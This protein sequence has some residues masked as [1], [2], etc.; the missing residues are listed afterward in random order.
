MG[1]SVE[2]QLGLTPTSIVEL[3]DEHWQRWVAEAHVLGAVPSPAR[4]REWCV[5]ASGAQVDAVQCALA[6]IAA[7]DGGDDA[8]AAL[9]LSALMLPAATK[10]AVQ[11]SHLSRDIDAI[12]AGQLW[13]EVRTF[14]WQSGHRFAGNVAWRVRVGAMREAGV[15]F[16]RATPNERLN[17]TALRFGSEAELG[18]L[19]EP[20]DVRHGVPVEADPYEESLRVLAWGRAERLITSADELLLLLL[21]KIA[22]EVHPPSRRCQ[23]ARTG[24]MTELA[25]GH[26][27]AVLGVSP[28]TI[29]RHTLHALTRLSSASHE[30]RAKSA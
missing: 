26:A 28:R 29:R 9:L 11:L 25:A 5:S 15:L 24:L 4:L 17:A 23:G 12:V 16:E 21:V 6:R 27:A 19:P 10:V 8:D 22:R 2:Q 7:I 30:F 20:F 1:M 3:V 18:A 13:L 14:N